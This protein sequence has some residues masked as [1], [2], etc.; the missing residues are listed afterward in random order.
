M[1][2]WAPACTLAGVFMQS[3]LRRAES[4]PAGA[5]THHVHEKYLQA[6]AE[7]LETNTFGANALRLQRYGLA[8]KVFGDQPAPEAEVARKAV[9]QR[10]D[11][12]SGP[13]PG[14]RARSGPWAC[15]WSRW[16]KPAWQEARTAFA[17]QIRGLLP[18][19]ASIC[20]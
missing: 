10:A 16:A 15:A 11:K 19:A 6:G 7:I 9:N 5:G 17:E 13:R 4:L 1:A 3:L 2:P 20:C 12:Q 8:D 14:L 18:R